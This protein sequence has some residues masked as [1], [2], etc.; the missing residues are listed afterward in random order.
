MQ[1]FKLLLSVGLSA[2]ALICSPC[3]VL[4]AATATR[5]NSAQT[6]FALAQKIAA[7]S[8]AAVEQR[9]ATDDRWQGPAMVPYVTFAHQSI[10]R[11]EQVETLGR[12]AQSLEYAASLEFTTNLNYSKYADSVISIALLTGFGFNG[13]NALDGDYASLTAISIAS[14][15]MDAINTSPDS[16]IGIL[17][18]ELYHDASTRAPLA[19][20]LAQLSHKLVTQLTQQ[21]AIF[22]AHGD[23]SLESQLILAKNV[24]DTLSDSTSQYMS[25]ESSWVY[26][27]NAPS[28][29]NDANLDSKLAAKMIPANLELPEMGLLKAMV[30]TSLASQEVKALIQKIR[31]EI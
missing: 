22:D 11:M 31:T 25:G 21:I 28:L 6:S 9:L 19:N 13:E 2:S 26:V 1:A 10:A 3:G 7:A 29:A 4:S 14:D 27:T 24:V 30:E 18:T 20:D 12:A 17:I 16:E 15:L 5:H 23:A 8:H